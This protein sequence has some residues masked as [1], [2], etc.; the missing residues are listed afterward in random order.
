LKAIADAA[1]K[2]ISDTPVTKRSARGAQKQTTSSAV[3]YKDFSSNKTW[4]GRGRRPAWLRGDPDH[5]LVTNLGSGS[6][7]NPDAPEPANDAAS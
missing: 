2:G 3:M 1:L 4:S 5:Y 7:G 6:K